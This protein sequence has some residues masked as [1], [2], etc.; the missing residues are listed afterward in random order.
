MNFICG[1]RHLR[2]GRFHICGLRHCDGDGK[3]DEAQLSGHDVQL[4]RS[5]YL[6]LEGLQSLRTGFD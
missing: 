4:P 3:D 6:V 2:L 1:R 5:C